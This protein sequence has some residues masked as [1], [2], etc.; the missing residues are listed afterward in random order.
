MAGLSHGSHAW[1]WRASPLHGT[2]CLRR[3]FT[4]LYNFSLNA[5]EH[6][7]SSNA[8]AWQQHSCGMGGHGRH[9]SQA[10]ECAALLLGAYLHRFSAP[11]LVQAPTNRSHNHPALQYGDIWVFEKDVQT[12]GWD[13]HG[14]GHH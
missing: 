8:R 5:E 10:L 9:G 14:H 11:S 13:D 1:A 7:V 3:R 4:M 2:V 6:W 12:N